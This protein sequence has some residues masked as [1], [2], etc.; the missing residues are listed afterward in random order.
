MQKIKLQLIF[1]TL[2]LCVL[3]A[4]ARLYHPVH[5]PPDSGVC[6]CGSVHSGQST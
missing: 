2:L 5:S 4:A 6:C 1:P 3:A